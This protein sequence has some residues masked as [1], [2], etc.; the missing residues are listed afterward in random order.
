MDSEWIDARIDGSDLRVGDLV[1]LSS[2]AWVSIARIVFGFVNREVLL[3]GPDSSEQDRTARDAT[4]QYHAPT[5]AKL[6]DADRERV[7]VTSITDDTMTVRP[8]PPPDS[9]PGWDHVPAEWYA[10]KDVFQLDKG[11][12][13]A[14]IVGRWQTSSYYYNEVRF[15]SAAWVR[16]AS[17]PERVRWLEERKRAVNADS[18]IVA[19]VDSESTYACAPSKQKFPGAVIHCPECGVTVAEGDW[20]SC[21]TEAE[22]DRHYAAIRGNA[23]P[24]YSSA[25][26]NADRLRYKAGPDA[27]SIRVS[28]VVPPDP[29]AAVRAEAKRMLASGA[30]PRVVLGALDACAMRG[31]PSAWL[32]ECTSALAQE[33]ARVA[34]DYPRQARERA[35]SP[36]YHGNR[37]GTC[38]WCALSRDRS[39]ARVAASHEPA[40][41]TADCEGE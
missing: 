21:V 24:R 40:W 23:A 37:A 14:Q 12:R 20:C 35:L 30:N 6:E 31:D 16:R 32:A 38:G 25:A 13:W 1:R 22:R 7:N 10:R 39:D 34:A 18:A 41:E 27:R 26:V 8:A 29:F 9:E 15:S 36:C 17:H 3:I 33:F 28:V 5:R 11:D 19:A 4:W 2:G